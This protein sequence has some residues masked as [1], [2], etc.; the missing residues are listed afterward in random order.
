MSEEANILSPTT[1]DELIARLLQQEFDDEARR[2]R[3]AEER[4]KRELESRR[5]GSPPSQPES[6]PGSQF[7]S[8][9]SPYSDE[10]KNQ[11]PDESSQSKLPGQSSFSINEARSAV[12]N[13]ISDVLGFIKNESP[14]RA[15]PP[16]PIDPPKSRELE[17]IS[18]TQTSPTMVQTPQRSPTS[19]TSAKAGSID[20]TKF[21]E[22]MRDR[23]AYPLT[24]Y[25]R[26]FLREFTRKQWTVNEQIKITHDFLDFMSQRLLENEVW[27]NASDADLENAREGM[28]KLLM[29]KLHQYTFCPDTADDA[30]KDEVLHKKIQIFRWLEL[31]HLDANISDQSDTFL[32]V[33]QQELL[34]INDYKAPRDKLICI[35]NCCKVIFGLLRQAEA[36]TS[37]DMFLPVLIYVVIQANPPKLISNVQY[38]SRFRNPAK[39]QSEAGYYLTNLMGAISFI[40]SLEAKNLSISQ[41]AFDRNISERML[42]LER[43]QLS[44]SPPIETSILSSSPITSSTPTTATA[45]KTIPQ[46]VPSLTS[47]SSTPKS[48]SFPSLNPERLSTLAIQVKK[49]LNMLNRWLSNNNDNIGSVLSPL[50]PTQTN[51]PFPSDLSSSSS[52]PPRSSH[53]SGPR[54]PG[55]GAFGDAEGFREQDDSDMGRKGNVKG[56][57]GDEKLPEMPLLMNIPDN[58]KQIL[59]DY[60]LQL[61]MALSLSI[62]ETGAARPKSVSPLASDTTAGETRGSKEGKNEV[63]GAEVGEEE[64]GKY[65]FD[66]EGSL[67]GMNGGSNTQSNSN[68]DEDEGRKE[69]IHE[70]YEKDGSL[71]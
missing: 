25:F 52:S 37:A 54:S 57:V 47:S 32:K 44:S 7:Y 15:P 64:E 38:I 18:S 22:M 70:L 8:T 9:I 55:T 5:Q 43:S 56:T 51:S 10:A 24:R 40:E 35:L 16:Q 71:I 39:L 50:S 2:L 61:A 66:F 1:D 29:N 65:K 6:Y 30:E 12:K 42:E 31:R 21:L 67:S 4:K 26:S 11:R 53:I 28:E 14:N 20:F 13:A 3:E 62:E 63:E 49:P 34:K 58:E 41:E 17:T 48:P 46:T 59:E 68:S 60:E 23:R 45:P 33:A 36:D 69:K 27:A 19:D